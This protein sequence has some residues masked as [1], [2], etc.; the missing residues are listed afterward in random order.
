MSLSQQ[1]RQKLLSILHPGNCMIVMHCYNC[2]YYLCFVYNMEKEK[3]ESSCKSLLI[4]LHRINDQFYGSSVYNFEHDLSAVI[5]C[6]LIAL[7]VLC[8]LYTVTQTETWTDR[9]GLCT[10]YSNGNFLTPQTPNPNPISDNLT[11]EL[12]NRRNEPRRDQ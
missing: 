12:P 2:I 4:C 5:K 1:T 11:P 6:D 7:S 9:L 8:I 10:I 3:H